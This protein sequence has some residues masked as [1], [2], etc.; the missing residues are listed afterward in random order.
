MTE[1]GITH[2]FLWWHLSQITCKFK[3]FL[4][5]NSE[6]LRTRFLSRYLLVQSVQNKVTQAPSSLS[7]RLHNNAVVHYQLKSSCWI[8]WHFSILL[9]IGLNFASGLE[10]TCPFE[11]H[12]KWQKKIIDMLL[13]YNFI[14]F[15]C[16]FAVWDERNYIFRHRYKVLYFFRRSKLKVTL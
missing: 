9:K 8:F 7:H 4:C 11:Q 13:I 12:W 6:F 3:C 10:L 2:Y 15:Q 14:R 16:N 5:K 1:Q